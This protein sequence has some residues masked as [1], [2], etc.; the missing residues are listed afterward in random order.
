MMTS[1]GSPI[2][3]KKAAAMVDNIIIESSSID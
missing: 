1:E 2:G 3:E